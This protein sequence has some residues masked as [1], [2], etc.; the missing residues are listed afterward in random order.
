MASV[1]RLPCTFSGASSLEYDRDLPLR[2][3][4]HQRTRQ[5]RATAASKSVLA[6]EE[7]PNGDAKAIEK[8]WVVSN[9][10][11]IGKRST[12][13]TVCACAPEEIRVGDFVDVLVSPE[14]V[15]RRGR[16]RDDLQVYFDLKGVVRLTTARELKVRGTHY[17]CGGMC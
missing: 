14:I 11:Q 15:Q 9:K 4:A 10:L 5:V 16:G 7:D 2:R 12:N 8:Q 3:R 6:A 1:G 17:A 13:G